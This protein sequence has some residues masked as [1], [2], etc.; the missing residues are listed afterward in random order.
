M[1][2]INLVNSYLAVSDY[3]VFIDFYLGCITNH[4]IVV[5]SFWCDS[6]IDNCGFVLNQP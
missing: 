1:Y 6:Q 5:D 3:S 4:V 2:L